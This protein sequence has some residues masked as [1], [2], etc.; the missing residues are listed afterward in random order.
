MQ[1]NIKALIPSTNSLIDKISLPKSNDK[2]ALTEATKIDYQIERAKPTQPVTSTSLKGEY[3]TLDLFF[4]TQ[5]N[6]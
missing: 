2:T 1:A 6:F 5:K 4:G 3:F